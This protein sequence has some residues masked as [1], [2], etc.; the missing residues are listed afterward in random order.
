MT[1]ASASASLTTVCGSSSLWFQSPFPRPLRQSVQAW[2]PKC[3]PTSH[4]RRGTVVC[5]NRTPTPFSENDRKTVL[6]AFFL[7]KALAET[8]NERIESN[9]GEALSVLGRWQAEQQ[10][11]IQ[12]FQEEVIIR[13]K[14]A[15]EKAALEAM[16]EKGVLSKPL[17]AS[18]DTL[19]SVSRSPDSKTEDPLDESLKD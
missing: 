18:S 2:S 9:V 14:K 6:D 5:S 7:G 3:L 10:K 19:T 8:L 17:A 4:P 1:T 11:Q 15:K 13:A 16:G 12:D